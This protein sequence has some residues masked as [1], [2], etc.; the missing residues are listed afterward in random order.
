[1]GELPRAITGI[2]EYATSP[3]GSG[4]VGVAVTVEIACCEVADCRPNLNGGRWEK[5]APALIQKNVDETFM[6]SSAQKI[7]S[8]IVV[9]VRRDNLPQRER[10]CAQVARFLKR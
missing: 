4:N 6:R 8:A 5:A 9:Y 10:I 7:W 3:S 1:M 2:K